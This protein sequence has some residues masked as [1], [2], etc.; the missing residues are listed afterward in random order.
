M[1]KELLYFDWTPIAVLINLGVLY[2]IMKRFLYKPVKKMLDLRESE[3]KTTYEQAESAKQTAENL[4][5]QYEEQIK[6][7]KDQ[8]GEIIKNATQKAISRG[9]EILADA[10]ANAQNIINRTNEQIAAEKKKAINEI[11]DEIADIAIS[12]ASSV[13]K[14]ELTQ[15]DHEKLIND[16]IENAGDAKWQN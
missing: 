1:P 12:A 3:V 9:D 7:A 16:F 6:T 14:K 4:K 8:A 15:A 2:F 10:A 11:K 5:V 13:L